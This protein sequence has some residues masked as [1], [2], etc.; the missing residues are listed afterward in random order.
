MFEE[1]IISLRDRAGRCAL[2]LTVATD[3]LTGKFYFR[4]NLELC[5]YVGYPNV[6]S[7]IS[8]HRL[9]EYKTEQLLFDPAKNAC[10]NS[11]AIVL[12]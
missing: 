2:H 6:H 8:L 1:Q 10:T 7:F 4:V 5:K 3:N 9:Q 12:C 11:M